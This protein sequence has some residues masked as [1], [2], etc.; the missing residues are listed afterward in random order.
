[1]TAGVNFEQISEVLKSDSNIIFALVFGSQALGKVNQLSDLDIGIFTKHDISLFQ[2]GKMVVALEK[3]SQKPVDLVLL[4][5]LYKRKPNFAFQVIS[6]AKLLFTRD[7]EFYVDFKKKVFLYYMDVKP[8]LER[9]KADV[10]RRIESGVFGR[11]N[12]A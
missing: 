9:V 3:V 10:D 1:M 7:E 5:D 4:N 6:S 11:R 2:L 8:L 12:Y